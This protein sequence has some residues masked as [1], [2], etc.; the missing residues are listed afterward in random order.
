MKEFEQLLPIK[1]ICN[2]YIEHILKLEITECKYK[3]LFIWR[4]KN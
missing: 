3:I 4:N 1:Q 2:K